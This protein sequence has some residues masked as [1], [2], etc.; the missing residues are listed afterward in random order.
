MEQTL[1]WVYVAVILIFVVLLFQ[2]WFWV[3]LFYIGAV[4]SFFICIACVIHFQIVFA[5]ITFFLS[6][7]LSNIAGVINA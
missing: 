2:R 5:V 3:G 6:A 7:I 4:A 1:M